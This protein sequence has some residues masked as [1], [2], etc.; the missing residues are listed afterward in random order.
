MAQFSKVKILKIVEDT[1]QA[2]DAEG[3]AIPGQ[4]TPRIRALVVPIKPDDIHI[5]LTAAGDEVINTFRALEGKNVLIP[6]RAGVTES[7][8]VYLSLDKSTTPDDIDLLV[9]KPK[10]AAK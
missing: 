2:Y 3:K 7:G 4:R 10:A 1:A 8:M 9:D 5:N 6:A